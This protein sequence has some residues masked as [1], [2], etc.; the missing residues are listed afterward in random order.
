MEGAQVVRRTGIMHLGSQ[1]LAALPAII[2][3][4]AILAYLLFGTLV[5]SVSWYDDQYRL[6]SFPPTFDNYADFVSDLAG[7]LLWKSLTMAVL[8]LLAAA[9][10]AAAMGYFLAIRAPEWARRWGVFLLLAAWALTS[11]R[12]FA[13]GHVQPGSSLW[14]V[15]PW[16]PVRFGEPPIAV[17]AYIAMPPMALAIY[18]SLRGDYLGLRWAEGGPSRIDRFV[19]ETIPRGSAGLLFGSIL[20]GATLFVDPAATEFYGGG[21]NLGIGSY[22]ATQASLIGGAPQAA[23]AAVIITLVLLGAATAGL[24]L[25]AG[26]LLASLRLARIGPLGP[27]IEGRDLS[28]IAFVL[29]ALATVLTLYTLFVPLVAAIAFSFNGEASL[30]ELGG[31]TTEWWVGGPTRTGLLADPDYL[32]FLWKS[33]GFAAAVAAAALPLALLASWALGTVG[34]RPRLLLRLSL[35]SGLAIPLFLLGAMGLFAL[36]PDLG[37]PTQVFLYAFFV[38]LPL[39]LGIAFLMT[40]PPS[41]SNVTFQSAK[42]RRV[43]TKRAVAGFLAAFAFVLGAY[44]RWNVGYSQSVWIAA[45]LGKRIATPSWDAAIAVLLLA[46]L[47]PL[48]AAWLVHRD[49]EPIRF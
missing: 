32:S 40:G 28:R 21:G 3:L 19:K 41:L 45:V 13:L 20:A 15:L 42:A 37:D 31:F 1:A 33:F 26:C 47:V 4:V 43:W 36:R 39:A 25:I 5:V 46:T 44:M 38:H 8:G 30:I 9:A 16:L 12:T 2:V 18:A 7:P 27:G 17:F 35:Y 24:L 34:W 48:A 22:I 10:P 23:V 49:R 6:N 29:T 11:A 14:V